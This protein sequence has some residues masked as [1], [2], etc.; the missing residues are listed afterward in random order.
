MT[1]CMYGCMQVSAERSIRTELIEDDGESRYKI[2]DIIGNNHATHT[3]SNH[4][5][6]LPVVCVSREEGR[7]R[8]GEPEG[9]R[10]DRRGNVSVV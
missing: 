9:L 5:H 7:D 3:P 6:S 2:T 10:D 1:V 8:G 4:T